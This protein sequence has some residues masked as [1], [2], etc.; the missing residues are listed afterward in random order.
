MISISVANLT[1]CS[2]TTYNKLQFIENK[3]QWEGNILFKTTLQNGNAF[4]ENNGITFFLS[5]YKSSCSHDIRNDKHTLCEHQEKAINNHAFKLI[6]INNNF[7]KPTASIKSKEYFNYYYGQDKSKWVNRAFAY[8]KISYNEIYNNIDWVIYSQGF[9]LKHDFIVH[10]GGKVED[11]ELVYNG[12]DKISLKEGDLILRTSIGEIIE[13]KPYAYQQIGGKTREIEVEFRLKGNTITYYIKDYDK[14][15]DLII[16]PQLI[17]STYTGSTSDNWGFTATYDK[18]GNGYLGGIVSD[19]GYPTTFGAFQSNFAGGNWDIGISKFD[20]TGENLIFSTY[21]GG[22]SSEMPHSLIVNEFNELV[23]FG[24]T[25]SSNFPITQSAYQ[26]NFVGGANVVYDGS[27]IFYNGCDIFVSRLKDDG[28][29]LLAST[30]IGGS[31][32]DGLNFRIGYHDYNGNDSLFCNYADGARGEL[33]TDDLNNIYVGTCTFSSN[34]PTTPN[35]FQPY[36]G[37]KQDGIVFKLDYSLSTLLFSSYLG[38]SHDDAIYSIDTDSDYRLYVAGGTVSHNFP[39]TTNAFSTSFNGGNTDGFIALISY[40]GSTILASTYFGSNERDQVYFVRTDKENSPHV[41]GQTHATGS[42]LIHNATYNTPNSGQFLAKFSPDLQTRVWSTVFGSGKGSPNISPSAF[43]IDNCGRILATGWGSFGNLSTLGMQTTPNA[44]SLN[45]DGGDFYIMSLSSDASTLEYASFFGAS[46]IADH[47]DGGTSRY[48]KFSNIYQAACAACGGRQGFPIYPTTAYSTSN[49]STNCNG[50]IFK[51]N[52]YDDFAVADFNIPEIGC[53]PITLNFINYGR[54]TSFLW[55]FGDGTSSTDT[56]ATHTYTEGGVYEV[57]LIAYLDNGCLSSDTLKR[58][59]YVLKNSSRTIPA[60]RT[61]RGTPVQIGI[62]PL[63][64]SNITFQWQPAELVTDPNISNPFA[65]V[66]QPTEFC[67]IISDGNCTDTIWQNVNIDFL[68]LDLIDTIKTCDSP[69]NLEITIDGASGFKFSDFSNFSLVL[70]SDTTLNHTDIYLHGSKYVYVMIEKDGCTGVD[71]IWFDFSGTS[72]NIQPTDVKCNGDSN[73]TAIATISG[74]ISPHL[75]QWSNG[76]S[77]ASLNSIDNLAPGDYSLTVTDNRGCHSTQEFTINSPNILS[78]QVTK[79]DNPCQGACIG[80]INLTPNGG[81][82][83][84]AVQWADGQTTLSLSN[85][86]AGTYNYILTD[87]NNCTTEDSIEILIAGVFNS[88]ITKIDNNC[89]GVCNGEAKVNLSGGRAPY[90]YKWSNNET[91]QTIT[92]L[93]NGI[94]SVQIA[95]QDGC[96][97]SNTVEIINKEIYQDFWVQA[98]SYEIYDGEPILLSCTELQEVTYQWSPSSYIYHPNRPK[99]YASPMQS[100]T[101]TI[102]VTDGKGCDYL[103]S[104]SIKVNVINC[105]E[106]NIFIPNIFTPNQDGK[107]DI[108]RVTGEYIRKMELYIFDR[109]GELVFSTKDINQGWDGTFRGEK[110]MAGVYFYRLEIECEK[111]RTFKKNGDITLIR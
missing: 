92:N 3:G 11:I 58:T 57:E 7:S 79:T 82:S 69:Y 71:S 53:A 101:Y 29:A 85:L 49:N 15:H 46:G 34:F 67:L 55:N 12:I 106:P 48:D 24:T 109:W 91:E 47:V 83:P 38:G 18:E 87:I 62:A 84:F 111:G 103:D 77:G 39:T 74:G 36:S 104:V 50:A 43:A 13:K 94:Y 9:D 102:F 33:I 2:D 72:L 4:I 86:C 66:D 23:I 76:E 1:F 93:C 95:D 75:Y 96:K 54:G 56:N 110:C 107:N 78:A 108:I 45:S 16:D 42:T 52:V 27:I 25:G 28:T 89:E 5:D 32:N 98:S 97:T 70:N 26:T 63:P 10:K 73:G 68:L 14:D 37:G 44:Y 64:S 30:Y 59:I 90:Y 105:G 22:S 21:I 19:I 31:D 88:I 40:N 17:F 35:A 61:C 20:A 99:T 51:Y 100:I 81:T 41:F 8:E 65:I 6:V 80:T 60:V